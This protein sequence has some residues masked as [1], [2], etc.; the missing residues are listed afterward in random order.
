M[1]NS[2]KIISWNVNGIRAVKKKGFNDFVSKYKPDILCIQETKSHPEQV[3]IVLDNYKYKYC[4][5][6]SKKGYSGTAIFSKINPLNEYPLDKTWFYVP[7]DSSCLILK[8]S[9]FHDLFEI[10]RH[11]KFSSLEASKMSTFQT[12]NILK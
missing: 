2:L 9:K 11:S 8:A 5:S 12:R 10:R 6:A 1:S 4:N 7:L 3:N